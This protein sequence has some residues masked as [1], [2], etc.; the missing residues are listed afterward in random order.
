[1]QFLPSSKVKATG[2]HIQGILGTDLSF[3]NRSSCMP[4]RERRHRALE[5]LINIGTFLAED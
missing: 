5:F 4:Q 3:T 2:S 1:M